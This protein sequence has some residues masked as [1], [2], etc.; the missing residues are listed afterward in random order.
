MPGTP[1]I[2]GDNTVLFGSA[3][4]YATGII[5]S[6]S[7]RT[8]S[9]VLEVK[10]NNGFTVAAIYFDHKN[11]CQ[12]EMIVQT[13]APTLAIADQVTICGVANCLVKDIEQMWANT[14]VRKYRVTA[15]KYEGMTLT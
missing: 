10:D 5:T 15:T 11:E 6:A 4:A 7:K 2:K 13:A 1:T 8:G 14:D 9:E 12:F 3:G